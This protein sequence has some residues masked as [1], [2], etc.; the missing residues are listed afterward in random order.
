VADPHNRA[1]DFRADEARRLVGVLPRVPAFGGARRLAEAG[2]VDENRAVL[3]DQRFGG[4]DEIAMV[5]GPAMRKQDLGRL[6]SADLDR[7][8]GAPVRAANQLRD[9][10]HI[11]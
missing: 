3:G 7:M 6:A 8:H 9:P 10:S 5:A 11:L 4:G 2:Q 1:A